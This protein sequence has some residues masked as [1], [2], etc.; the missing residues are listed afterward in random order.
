MGKSTARDNI[1]DT[2]HISCAK[3]CCDEESTKEESTKEE[4]S[5]IINVF[6]EH[7]NFPSC[8]GAIDQ[9]HIQ[10]IKPIADSKF[11]NYKKVFSYELLA[12]ADAALTRFSQMLDNGLHL[13]ELS[14][15]RGMGSSFTR[16]CLWGMRPLL[17]VST[18]Y[19]LI[20]ITHCVE[21]RIFNYYL[22]RLRVVKCT[23]GI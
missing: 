16:L 22:S 1:H 5:N 21:K 8:V 19:D 12:V 13:P 17:C 10:I 9:K 11:F 15:A 7:C 4:W 2:S 23:F 6:W 14:T 18:C 3:G 20:Q